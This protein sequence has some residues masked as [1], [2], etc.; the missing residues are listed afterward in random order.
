MKL[1]S[2]AHVVVRSSRRVSGKD[3]AQ[4]WVCWVC[5]L[6]WVMATLAGL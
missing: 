5:G 3:R 4:A 6:R 2:D 1:P